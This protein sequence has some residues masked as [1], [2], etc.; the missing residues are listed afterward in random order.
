MEQC[1]VSSSADTG[2]VRCALDVDARMLFSA[3]MI[4]TTWGRFVYL[5]RACRAVHLFDATERFTLVFALAR[6]RLAVT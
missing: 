5:A 4:A 1:K 3:R 6:R 2:A